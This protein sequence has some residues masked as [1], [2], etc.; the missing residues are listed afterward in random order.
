MSHVDFKKWQCPL[1]VVIFQMFLSNLR[2]CNVA[3]R[4]LE[5]AMSPVDFKGQGH[6]V[7]GP[8]RWGVYLLRD[9][10]MASEALTR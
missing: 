7:W 9:V 1:A 2:K 5:N 3:C 4:I 6:P 8:L 10:T